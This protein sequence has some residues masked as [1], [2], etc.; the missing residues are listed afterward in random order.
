LTGALALAGGSAL[1]PGVTPAHSDPATATASPLSPEDA[2]V[3]VRTANTLRSSRGSGF[4]VG[5]G[6]WVV[7]A[8]HVVSVDL[9]K[10]RRASDQTV[11]VYSPWTGR[12][13]EAK[14]AA[15]DGVA[16]V[17]LIRMPQA[18]FPALPLE[19]VDQS[20]PNAALSALK[21]R[22]LRLYGFPL[23][24]GEAT[25]AALARPEHNDSK[26]REI[27]RR[28][29]TNLCVLNPCPDA[30]PGWSGGPMV[31]LDRGAVVAVFHSLYRKDEEDKGV[32]AG[33][34]S[35]YLAPLFK[36]A[37]IADMSV[38]A[39]VK[40]PTQPRGA[41]SRELMAAEIRSLAWSSSAKW[42]KAEEEQREILTLAPTDVAARVELGRVL[43]AQQRYSDAIRELR[44]AVKLA[45]GSM[46]AHLLLGRALHQDYDP[47]GAVAELQA[48]LTASPGEVEPQLVL[49]QV[50]EDNQRPQQAEEVLRRT[51]QGAPD[52]PVVVFR[53]GSLLTRT[54]AGQK[55][56]EEEGLK[57]LAQASEMSSADPVLSFIPVGYARSLEVIRKWKEAESAYRQALRVDPENAAAHYY[58]AL[59]YFRQNRLDD[60]QIQL[61]A[62]ILI[63]TISDD[64][65]EAFRALQVKINEKGG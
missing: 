53:L 56:R 2:I 62:G 60:A 14:V 28:G 55:P 22:P 32:P 46:Q 37:G 54:A 49:A 8:S 39:T 11:L 50:H 19:T 35:G 58:L 5:D 43:F 12:P 9:G 15:V 6:G 25:V 41:K 10:G 24:Y 47:K 27:T 48:A 29:E 45:P 17:A 4:L 18:G 36:Q 44:E 20:D 7:T 52:H 1:L 3:M 13:Y 31:S 59:L 33:S 23:T 38:L 57:L 64:M 65:L 34:L 26:L 16:D 51:M 21:D 40:P 30:Q 42:K 63:K 61:N